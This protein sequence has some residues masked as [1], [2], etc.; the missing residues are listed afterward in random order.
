[1]RDIIF[2]A[3]RKDNNEWVEG[4]L[5]ELWTPLSNREINQ[6]IVPRTSHFQRDGITPLTIV[7]VKPE[8]VSQFTGLLD[9]KGNKIFEGD[10]LNC[11]GYGCVVFFENGAFKTEYKHSEDG[12][13]LSIEDLG[14]KSFI[15]QGN[16]HD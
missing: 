8:T 4:C 16:I 2:K 9:K 10:M 6:G 14:V 7:P 1:M 5:I 15:I 12:E 13:V 3:K 11:N